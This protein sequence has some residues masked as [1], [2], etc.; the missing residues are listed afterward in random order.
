[1]GSVL[2][3]ELGRSGAPSPRAPGKGASSTLSRSSHSSCGLDSAT[4][5]GAVSLGGHR[6]PPHL[7]DKRTTCPPEGSMRWC[8]CTKGLET[9]PAIISWGKK[10]ETLE[11]CTGQC[12]IKHQDEGAWITGAGAEGKGTRGG[13]TKAPPGQRVHTLTLG[14]VSMRGYGRRE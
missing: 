7:G 11:K 14:H 13:R 5:S 4:G 8:V 10:T 3:S 9:Q 1:M 2:C 6:W 12:A